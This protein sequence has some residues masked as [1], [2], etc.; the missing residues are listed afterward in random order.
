[1]LPLLPLEDLDGLLEEPPLLE[2]PLANDGFA[3][4]VSTT[5]AA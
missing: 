4:I 1:L 3:V 5:G 2:P